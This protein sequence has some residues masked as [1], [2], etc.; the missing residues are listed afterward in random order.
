MRSQIKITALFAFMAFFANAQN[1]VTVTV[2]GL[3]SSKGNLMLEMVDAK[4]KVVVQ[5][6]ATIENKKSTIVLSDVKNGTYAIRFYH[7]EN[8]NQKMDTGTFGIPTEGYGFS[9]NAR[10]F[11]GP[12][13]LEDMLFTV[14][15]DVKLTLKTKN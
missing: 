6:V 1:T 8:N 2:T 13:D 14:S 7:D 11:M 3:K 5:K 12:P 10:G 4:D 15:G 9:N